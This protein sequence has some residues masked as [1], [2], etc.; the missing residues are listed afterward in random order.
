MCSYIQLP[1]RSSTVNLAQSQETY[2]IYGTQ[3]GPFH[4]NPMVNNGC[5]NGLNNIVV[6]LYGVDVKRFC[7]ISTHCVQI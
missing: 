4:G 3:M 7:R 1:L 5:C 6:L 2:M